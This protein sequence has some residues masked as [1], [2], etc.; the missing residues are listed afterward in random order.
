MIREKIDASKERQIILYSIISTK[1]L[2]EI[3][4]KARID[5]FKSPYAKTVWGWISAYFDEFAEAPNKDIQSIY[6]AHKIEVQEDEE[7][8]AIA[9]FLQSLSDS[10]EEINN[11][12]Y[13]VSQAIEWLNIRAQENLIEALKD[14]IARKD[15]ESGNEAIAEY[16][17]IERHQTKGVSLLTDVQTSLEAFL[18]GED[19][20]FTFPGTIGLTIGEFR[21]TDF[22]SFLGYM[23]RGKTF[24]LWET[25]KEAMFASNKVL[26]LSLEMPQ[27]QILKRIW[28]SLSKKPK[29]TKTVR[30]PY[31]VEDAISTPEERK[32][33]IEYE[34]KEMEGFIPDIA[35]FQNWVKRF[36]LY[37]HGGDL[38]VVSM[39]SRSV[40][41]KDIEVYLNNLEYYDKWI[42]DVVVIDYA[43][44]ISS[45][46]KGEYRHQ[47]DDI[48]ANLRRLALERNICVVTASQSGRAAAKADSTDETIAEDIRKIAHVTKMIAI[49]ATNEE[50]ANGIYRIAQ[51]AERDDEQHF[52]QSLVLSCLDLGQVCIDSRFRSEVMRDER[53]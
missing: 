52:E 50:K 28:R 26:F 49:N 35:W 25:A 42:P 17:S 18:D 16:A 53:I 12:D 30:I 45:K 21:R 13:A 32:Y 39:P 8:E 31:F 48:W 6:T 15:I 36:K 46:L 40:T 9:T 51:L 4:S 22:I 34:E 20:L 5:L 1:F 38:R 33:I 27:K 10:E 2:S 19:T 29:R 43:D 11:I 47:L 23:K 7:E 37:F 3:R 24:W 14:A 41:V 44:L